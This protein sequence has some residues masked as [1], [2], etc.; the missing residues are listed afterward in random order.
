MAYV[1]DLGIII[2]MVLIFGASIPVAAANWILENISTVAVVLLIKSLLFVGKG[3]FAK[4]QKPTYYLI[5]LITLLLDIVRN[6][7][8]L[9]IGV[10]FLSSLFKH[11]LFGLV[12]GFVDLLIG[13]GIALAITEGPAY[14]IYSCMWDAPSEQEPLDSS[15]LNFF[16]FS[17][18]GLEA[19]SIIALYLIF[20][21]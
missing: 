5:V 16:F 18:C 1:S 7:V 15:E 17:C 21:A 2:L 3:F 11:G 14:F 10:D 9:Y 4:K 20:I 19:A 8:F 6:G 13:G 12:L